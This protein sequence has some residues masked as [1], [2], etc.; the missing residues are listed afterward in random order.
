MPSLAYLAAAIGTLPGT[1]FAEAKGANCSDFLTAGSLHPRYRTASL[2]VRS[3]IGG[4]CDAETRVKHC[5]LKVPI[6]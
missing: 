4:R 1:A 3:C 6:I 5:N 2:W